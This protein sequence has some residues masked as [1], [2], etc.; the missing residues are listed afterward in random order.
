MADAAHELRSPLTALSLQAE[1][2]E[3]VDMS[4]QARDRLLTLK[5]GLQRSRMLLDQLLALARAQQTANTDSS[6]I[7]VQQLFREV[8]EDLIALAE[9]RKI[10]LGVVGTDDVKLLIQAIDMTVIIKNIVD[11]GIRY[12]PVGGTIDMSVK[13]YDSGIV[14]QFDDSGPGIPEE[15]R[16]RVF[17][18]FYRILGNDEMGSG[19]G[20]SIVKSITD[21]IGADISLGYADESRNSGLSV[22]IFFPRSLK[23]P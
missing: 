6:C 19:L 4:V 15:E 23:C 11:N 17:D 20:L 14:L 8:L 10:D 9:A 22:K 13:I 2:L 3:A 18:P 21:R 5:S 12:T 16:E 7:S 1:R